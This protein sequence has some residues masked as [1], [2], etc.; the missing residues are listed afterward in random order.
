MARR[1]W[2]LLNARLVASLAAA[3]ALLVVLVVLPA[4]VARGLLH[5]PRCSCDVALSDYGVSYVNFTARAL[6]GVA[7]SGWIVAPE[8]EGSVFVLLHP[9]GGCR[10]APPVLNLSLELAR[11][12]YVVVVFD[13]RGHGC[14]GGVSTLGVKEMLDAKAAINYV[15]SRYPDRRIYLAGFGMGASVAVIEA[16]S[17]PLVAGVVADAPYCRLAGF[18]DKLVRLRTHLPLS[19]LVAAY[20]RLFYHTILDTGFGPCM[21]GGVEKPLL[22]FHEEGDPLVSRS[23]AEHVAALSPCSRLVEVPDAGHAEAIEKLGAAKYVDIVEEYF[24]NATR[25]CPIGWPPTG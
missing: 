8:N 22:V 4:Y 5:P 14:S 11:R 16:A 25:A 15:A 12:G 2:L 7:V 9:Y 20:T 17:D 19:S 3:A 10:S 1:Y 6:D 24:A 23:D 13:F 21:L 18:L